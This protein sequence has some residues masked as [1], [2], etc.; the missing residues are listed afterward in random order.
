MT[1]D[2][3]IAFTVNVSIFLSNCLSATNFINK[4]VSSCWRKEGKNRNGFGLTTFDFPSFNHND[5]V[6]VRK[7]RLIPKCNMNEHVKSIKMNLRTTI[8]PILMIWR[9]DAS[10]P[11][12]KCISIARCEMSSLYEWK[13]IGTFQNN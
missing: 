7:S 2:N 9:Y 4:T 12:K 1:P 11:N 3:Y 8:S 13:I 5:Y 10:E 6:K